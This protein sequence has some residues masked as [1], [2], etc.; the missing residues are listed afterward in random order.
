[1]IQVGRKILTSLAYF[2]ME[3][4]SKTLEDGFREGIT[5]EIAWIY[6]RQIAQGL[7]YIHSKSLIR[8]DM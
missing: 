5:K 7:D 6:F 3:F 4:W 2:L 8:R 1:M